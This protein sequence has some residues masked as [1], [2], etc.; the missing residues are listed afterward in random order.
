MPGEEEKF[1]TPVGDGDYVVEADECIES[2]ASE[3][4][5]FWETIWNDPQNAKVKEERKDP[6][7]ILPGDR[8]Y[9]REIE[10][11]KETGETDKRHTFVRKGVPSALH[12]QF[13]IGGEPRQGVAYRLSLGDIEFKGS[14]DDKGRISHPVPPD[15][16]GG[17]LTIG[18]PDAEEVYVLVVRGLDPINTISG[19]QQ[20]LHNL[21]FNPGPIDGIVG[22]L[23][24]A[25]VRLF[26]EHTDLDPDGIAGPKTQAK[27]KEW[28]GA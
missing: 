3:N 15:T 12:M 4:G 7:L 19:I 9:V 26:Q 18:P 17:V 10:T 21:N 11:K 24:R 13:L 6:N 2:I 22:P 25:S 1:S 16:V 8:L 20:R 14:T 23:T 28:Y 27:L 5:L